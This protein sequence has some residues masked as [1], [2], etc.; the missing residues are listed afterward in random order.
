MKKCAACH[1]W[2]KGGK[3]KVG[4]NLYG[5]LGRPAGSVPGF[6]YSSGMQARAG[7][8]G[9]WSYDSLGEFLASPK[10]YIKGTAMALG[11]KKSS[12]R[13]NVIMFLR[14]QA[15]TPMDLPAAAAAEPAATEPAATEPAPTEPAPAS[16]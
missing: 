10:K 5:V 4:P 9:A 13:A 7:E 16:E 2:D 6:K 1:T 11:T 15:D 3:N 14:G 8:I 12:E